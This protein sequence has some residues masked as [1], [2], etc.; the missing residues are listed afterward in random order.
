MDHFLHGFLD[1]FRP[2]LLPNLQVF[3]KTNLEMLGGKGGHE[4]Q[5]QAVN[6]EGRIADIQVRA[7]DAP[8][9]PLKVALGI[10]SP[11]SD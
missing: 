6:E 10:R 1:A 3:F 11:Y 2:Q 7:N 9:N 8:G 4:D 5:A